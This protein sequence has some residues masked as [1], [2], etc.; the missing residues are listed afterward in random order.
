MLDE[1]YIEAIPQVL[2]K[3]TQEQLFKV[4]FLDNKIIIVSVE[5]EFSRS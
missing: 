4:H 5:H 1:K 2:A 3:I